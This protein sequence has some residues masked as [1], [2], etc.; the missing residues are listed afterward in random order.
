MSCVWD[1]GRHLAAEMGRGLPIFHLPKR[2]HPGFAC[3]S[4]LPDTTVVITV[5]TR[6]PALIHLRSQR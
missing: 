4:I 2:V 3:I 6:D 1:N 5:L